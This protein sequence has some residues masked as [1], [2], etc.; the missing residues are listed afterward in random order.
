[1]LYAIKSSFTT[2]TT[3]VTASS[4]GTLG[5]RLELASNGI[6]AAI[7]GALLKGTT[8]AFFVL[9]YYLVATIATHLDLFEYI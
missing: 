2:Y 6:T 4:A 8:V 7:R 9:F 1:M 3:L 5:F